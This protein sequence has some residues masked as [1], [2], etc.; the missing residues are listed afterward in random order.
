[1]QGNELGELYRVFRR[2]WRF[3][4]GA[5]FGVL[6]VSVLYLLVAPRKYEVE[7][8]LLYRENMAVSPF[9]A[10]SQATEG[11]GGLGAF[12]GLG[13]NLD[14]QVVALSSLDPFVA[15][16]RK[17]PEEDLRALTRPNPLTFPL[18]MVRRLLFPPSPPRPPYLKAA[19]KLQKRVTIEPVGASGV[20][21]IVYQDTDRERVMRVVRLLVEEAHHLSKEN[22]SEYYRRAAR[23]LE[24]QA[25]LVLDSLNL[26]TDSFVTFQK[27]SHLFSLPEQ[28]GALA[29]TLQELARMEAEARALFAAL[30][31]QVKEVDTR[32][33][34]LLSLLQDS[35]V[36]QIP[37]NRV[38]W[39]SLVALRVEYSRLLVQGTD[40]LSP[41]M[42]DLRRR[43]RAA[44]QAF[45]HRLQTVERHV[46]WGNPAT[47]LDSLQALEISLNLQYVSTRAQIQALKRLQMQYKTALDTL[48]EQVVRFL[49][50][51]A[52]FSYLSSLYAGLLAQK[53]QMLALA[54]NPVSA[55][56]EVQGIHPPGDP[57][58]PRPLLVLVLAVFVGTVGGVG[59]VLGR[60][61]VRTRLEVPDDLRALGGAVLGIYDLSESTT[62]PEVLARVLEWRSRQSPAP[63]RRLA[64]AGVIPEGAG[65][66]L[67]QAISR[68]LEALHIPGTPLSLRPGEDVQLLS[69]LHRPTQDLWVVYITPEPSDET[70]RT[71]LIH[72]DA[73]VLLVSPGV[74]LPQ[75]EAWVSLL[76]SAETEFLGW[77]FIKPGSIP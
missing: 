57:V 58:S 43:I 28:L 25:A 13:S 75:L 16:C 17:L 34:T 67:L 61:L 36:Y 62:Y 14:N 20:I 56:Y 47:I 2:E 65:T 41:R 69:M 21:R 55:F 27:T 8:R 1:M 24:Q 19:I 48:P 5:F 18:R 51:Q 3:F 45:L 44:E 40:S 71:L 32:R 49:Q 4:A 6:L 59:A 50:L 74:E 31:A 29:S 37:E 10:L 76:Q 22:F 15:V 11:F 70:L 38:L 73:V 68:T 46:L 9:M 23:S 72:A 63:P 7:A 60:E 54:R 42:V 12:L 53:D 64:F 52:R 66:A 30:N 77:A 26:V 33:Q 39:D 35:T